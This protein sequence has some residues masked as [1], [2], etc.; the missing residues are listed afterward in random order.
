M[1]LYIDAFLAVSFGNNTR[2]GPASG[3]ILAQFAQTCFDVAFIGT[4]RMICE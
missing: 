1:Y 3:F 2:E 4:K